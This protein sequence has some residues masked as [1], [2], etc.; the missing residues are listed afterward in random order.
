MTHR[1]IDENETHFFVKETCEC[2]KFYE[3]VFE[4]VEG[5]VRT[6][7]CKC[8]KKLNYIL[9]EIPYTSFIEI[10]RKLEYLNYIGEIL[11]YFIVH[12][13]FSSYTC[14]YFSSSVYQREMWFWFIGIVVS[15]SIISSIIYTHYHTKYTVYKE[16]M[17]VMNTEKMKKKKEKS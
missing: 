7:K 15:I 14:M 16:I 4:K 10:A 5:N 8:G 1:I 3:F 12:S 11:L 13:V 17:D 9:G 2:G 6:K